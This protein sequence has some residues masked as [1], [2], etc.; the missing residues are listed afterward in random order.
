MPYY[1]ISCDVILFFGVIFGA[2]L[3]LLAIAH[4]KQGMIQKYHKTGNQTEKAQFGNKKTEA[5]EIQYPQ[6]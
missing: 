5:K 1:V 4:S 6:N 2:F 3:I